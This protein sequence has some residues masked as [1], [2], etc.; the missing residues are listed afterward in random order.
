MIKTYR[1]WNPV[2]PTYRPTLRFWRERFRR[3]LDQSAGKAMTR[4]G[5]KARYGPSFRRPGTHATG[6]RAGTRNAERA[7]ERTEGVP[8]I[9][10][11]ECSF[12][13]HCNR[14]ARSLNQCIT[15]GPFYSINSSRRVLLLSVVS[16]KLWPFTSKLAQVWGMTRRNLQN[17][18]KKWINFKE[19]GQIVRETVLSDKKVIKVS[20]W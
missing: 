7:S 2:G 15:L 17:G 18:G 14:N 9:R 10:L 12:F 20:H 19:K 6:R 13:N 1:T 8:S 16:W 4:D 5:R 3:S 11:S